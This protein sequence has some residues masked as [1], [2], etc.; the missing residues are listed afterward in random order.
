[1]NYIIKIFINLLFIIK[2]ALDFHN[3]KRNNKN[4]NDFGKYFEGYTDYWKNGS[5]CP[6]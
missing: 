1:M 6:F 3:E 4:I 2:V 5:L